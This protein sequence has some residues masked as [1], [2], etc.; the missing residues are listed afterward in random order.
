MFYSF[1]GLDGTGKTTQIRL[2]ADWLRAKGNEVITCVDPGSTPL[3][4]AVRAILLDR[5]DLHIARRS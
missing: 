1:D 5:N 3:G 4:E 2:F